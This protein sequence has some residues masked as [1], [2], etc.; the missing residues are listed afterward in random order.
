MKS[1]GLYGE[2]KANRRRSWFLVA[3][4]ALLLA[5]LGTVLGAVSGDPLTG[6]VAAWAVAV[7]FLTVTWYG[8]A[9]MTLAASDARPA[10]P[11]RDRMLINTVDEMALASGLPRPD[12]FII[13]DTAPNAFATGRDPQHAA[14]AVTRGLYQKLDRDELQGVVAHELSHIR[15]HD[16][17]YTT[18]VAVTVGAIALLADF[19][20]RHMWWG[21]G[22]RRAR[23]PGAGA[24]MIAVALLVAIL[25]PISARLLQAAVSRRRETLADL[26]GAEMT[27]YPEALARAL[28]KIAGDPEV[29]EVA[30]RATAPL[31][32]VDPIKEFE[33]RARGLLRTH[34]PTAER[35][36]RL[37]SL[38][39]PDHPP[40]PR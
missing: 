7:V 6:L 26:S 16:I 29:L 33:K 12:I 30:N 14:I 22:P 1:R 17:R 35:V 8:G 23:N 32:I 11:E 10:D 15:N 5:L 36:A 28:E 24:I 39:L 3:G 38:V 19:A 27:R 37:R 25:A 2:I 4:I 40:V 18:L 34:P 9:Q 31:Y 13:D 20:I 21:G